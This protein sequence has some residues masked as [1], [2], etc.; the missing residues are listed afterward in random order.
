MIQHADHMYTGEEERVAQTIAR[1]AD[2]LL[3]T[4]NHVLECPNPR[5]TAIYNG[6][7]QG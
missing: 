6:H 7:L 5:K 2:S 3:R 4:A 1:S